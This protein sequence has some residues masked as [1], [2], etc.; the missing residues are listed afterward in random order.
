MRTIHHKSYDEAIKDLLHYAKLGR[1]VG[2]RRNV[3][4]GWDVHVF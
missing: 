4:G 3:K 2:M 1:K